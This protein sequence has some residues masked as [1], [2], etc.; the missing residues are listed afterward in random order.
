MKRGL[1]H[2]TA[3]ARVAVLGVTSGFD[4]GPLRAR[5]AA[6]LARLKAEV[7]ALKEELRIKDARMASIPPH[8]RPHYPPKERLAILLLRA[9]MG[10]N[11]AQT[12]RRFEVTSAT[13]GNWLRRLDEEGRDALVQTRRPVNRFPDFVAALVQELKRTVPTMGTRRIAN[14]LARAGLQLA[15][16]SVE[17]LAGRKLPAPST[18]PAVPTTTGEEKEPASR[19]S[20]RIVTAR[21]AHHVWHVDITT[22]P[23][24]GGFWTPWWP[25]SLPTCWPFCWHIVVVVDHFSRAP[26]ARGVFKQQPTADEVCAVLDRGVGSPVALLDTSSATRATSS[27]ARPTTPGARGEA[28]SRASAPSASTAPSPSSSASSAH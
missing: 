18:P 11:A 10:W 3:L 1:L 8:R 20:G 28:P 22:M 21:F 2:A 26:V 7:A 23:T 16:T 25:F 9:A 5:E 17:R 27:P 12:A 4:D 24:V 14:T 13:I 19:A 15:K 6:E